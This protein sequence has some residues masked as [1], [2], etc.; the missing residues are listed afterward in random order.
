M[1]RLIVDAMPASVPVV[2]FAGPMAFEG[3][4]RPGLVGLVGAHR[5]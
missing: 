3:P 2:S 1:A 4:L 5:Q